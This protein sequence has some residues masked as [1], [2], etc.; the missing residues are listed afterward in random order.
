M[1]MY[2]Y[3]GGEQVKIF[4]SPIFSPKDSMGTEGASTWHSGGGMR[5]FE[6]G[7]ELPLKTLY[8][9]YPE[10]F[11]MHD[12]RFEYREVWIIVD[13]KLKELTTYEKLTNDDIMGP[14]LDYY[15]RELNI[16]T[17][18][19]FSLIKKE[20]EKAREE[21]RKIEYSL[22]PKGVVHAV[23]NNLEEFQAKEKEWDQV[24]Y[25]ASAAFSEKWFVKDEYLDEKDF[26]EAID[27]FLFHNES[28][29]N[30]SIGDH[31]KPFEMYTQ[32]LSYV[33]SLILAD[34]DIIDKYKAWLNA[35][36]MLNEIDFDNL[37]NVI[38]KQSKVGSS[39]F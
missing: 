20:A 6:V 5:S 15:G 14:V 30:K 34:P 3:L 33:R 12:F 26:G 38:M 1:G 21:D 9:Q 27:V 18:E 39:S 4:Y 25:Q 29:N 7:D 28:K 22:F 24:K 31:Y 37:I 17:V 32:C 35:P 19:D 10:N 11:L 16:K 36:E 23:R 8:Y 2:D 13:G